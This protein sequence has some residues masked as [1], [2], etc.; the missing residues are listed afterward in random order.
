MPCKPQAL[1][2][3]P[4]PWKESWV[5]SRLWPGALSWNNFLDVVFL[6]AL[7]SLY[8]A[9][10]TS[11]NMSQSNTPHARPAHTPVRVLLSPPS[12][13]TM[14]PNSSKPLPKYYFLLVTPCCL[15][16]HL[17]G[18]GMSLLT[19]KRKGGEEGKLQE[20]EERGRG[21][22]GN[23]KVWKGHPHFTFP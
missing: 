7:Y 5:P 21:E 15:W 16:A 23:E 11:K 2:T 4:K 17:G 3:I 20:G 1:R 22:K 14:P 8:S 6:Q 9:S 10:S 12:V 18:S 13:I 19:P